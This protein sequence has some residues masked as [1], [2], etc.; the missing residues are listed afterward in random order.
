[1]EITVIIVA[2]REH[3]GPTP[4][5]PGP[6]DAAIGSGL[7]VQPGRVVVLTADDATDSY[8][9]RCWTRYRGVSVERVEPGTDEEIVGGWLGRADISDSDPGGAA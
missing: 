2:R 9:R 6:L 5:L 3:L 8:V 4:H 7:D 1:M